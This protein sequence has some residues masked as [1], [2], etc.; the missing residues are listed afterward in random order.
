MKINLGIQFS[1]E[2]SIEYLLSINSFEDEL[3]TY[4]NKKKYGEKILKIYVGIICVSKG[5]EPFFTVRPLKILRKE[6]SLEYEFKL[7][8]NEFINSDK[9]KRDKILSFEFLKKSKEILS[10]K[11]I[12]GFD[13]EKFVNDLEL[14]FKENNYI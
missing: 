5:F 12:K 13:T 11:K 8:F 2:F 4:F 1:R 9:E 14:F 3:N 7:D 10:T 6:P